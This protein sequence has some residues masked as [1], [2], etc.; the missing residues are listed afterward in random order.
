MDA[1]G[2]NMETQILRRSLL[3]KVLAD[4]IQDFLE[5]TCRLPEKERLY[6][7]HELAKKSFSAEVIE[8]HPAFSVENK[9]IVVGNITADECWLYVPKTQKIL[10]AIWRD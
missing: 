10:K 6:L 5:I 4:I 9:I 7:L 8:I 2:G 3:S 1:L